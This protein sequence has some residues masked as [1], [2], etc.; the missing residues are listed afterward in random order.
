MEWTLKKS[1]GIQVK[2]SAK[3]SRLQQKCRSVI[4]YNEHKSTAIEMHRRGK[5]YLCSNQD[6][7]AGVL[8]HEMDTKAKVMECRAKESAKVS[9]LQQKCRS[10]IT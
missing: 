3:A 6:R 4:T 10:V 8:S 1:H 7:H 9:R 2:E 5:I